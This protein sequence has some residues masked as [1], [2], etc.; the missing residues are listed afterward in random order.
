MTSGAPHLTVQGMLPQHKQVVELQRNFNLAPED[1]ALELS[2]P[3]EE[4]QKALVLHAPQ[5]TYGIPE[6]DRLHV[7]EVVM[8]EL[9]D[10]ATNTEHDDDARHLNVRLKAIMFL[11]KENTTQDRREKEDRGLDGPRNVH[12]HLHETNKALE[13]AK[14][15]KAAIV[16]VAA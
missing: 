8:R 2:M 6:K 12:F 10:I 5:R 4:V 3:L 15:A 1:I 16:E 7:Q 11:Q 14:R 13:A 9:M